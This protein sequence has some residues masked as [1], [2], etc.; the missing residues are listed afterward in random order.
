[1]RVPASEGLVLFVSV[2]AAL[3]LLS[4]CGDDESPKPVT[5]LELS[6]DSAGVEVAQALEITATVTGGENHAVTWYVNGL[7]GGDDVVG[8]IAPGNPATYRAPDSVP[9]VPQVS[10]K[11]VSQEDTSKMDSCCV[12]VR[13]TIT[14]VDSA[15]GD[16]ETGTGITTRPVRS[17]ARGLAI[18]ED[19]LQLSRM[20]VEIRPGTYLE[21]D[22]GVALGISLRSSAGDPASVTIDAGGLGRV[23]WWN[24]EQADTMAGLTLTGG[25]ATEAS[26]YSG[27]GGG[28]FIGGSGIV[29]KCILRDNVADQA[30]GGIM[31][32][33][34][35]SPKIL[36]CTFVGNSAVSGS[37]FCCWDH[38]TP[39]LSECTFYG[40]HS[41]SQYGT[42]YC[43]S[44]SPA[45]ITRTVIAFNTGAPGVRCFD[46]ESTPTLTCCDVN[47]NELGD[48]VGCIESQEVVNGNFSANPAFC[49]APNG[50][51]RLR[52][53]SPCLPG[54]H[55][56]GYPCDG[57][58][59]AWGEGTGC[60]PIY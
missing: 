59:G 10:V 48:W 60:P 36:G 51:L 32:W 43:R 2:A 56:T 52:S 39:A 55:P 41:L 28:V 20:T 14:Y 8:T 4:G 21:H 54:N 42:V 3:A 58:I 17:I 31:T 22:L 29:R 9:A 12:T 16:D 26:V 33:N 27:W 30:G 13:F 38:S 11:A 7:A 34:H 15:A 53:G 49:D 45:V 35:S 50:D 44:N 1:M 24:S 40:N 18:A 6:V 5:G 57:V 19:R 37:G 23:V 25:H 46:E 47:G